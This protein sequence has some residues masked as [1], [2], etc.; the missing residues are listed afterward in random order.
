MVSGNDSEILVACSRNFPREN[1][2]IEAKNIIIATG[3]VPT[4][5]PGIEFDEKVIVSS[6]GVL[7]LDKDPNKMDVVGG[8]YISLEMGS[9]WSRLGAKVEVIEIMDHAVTLEEP[10]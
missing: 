1:C 7:K 2:E 6:T 10:N 5:L 3:S 4:S 8:G 9:E